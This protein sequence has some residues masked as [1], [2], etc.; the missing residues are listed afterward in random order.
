MLKSELIRRLA[1]SSPGYTLT[2]SERAVSCVLDRITEAVVQGDRVE[3]RGFGSFEARTMPARER[4]NPRDLSPVTVPAS[5]KLAF[6]CSRKV[7]ERINSAAG[8][9]SDATTLP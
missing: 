7:T 5:R 3:L 9:K 2:A 4:H 6:R 8:S 1:G